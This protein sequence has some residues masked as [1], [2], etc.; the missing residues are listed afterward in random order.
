MALKKSQRMLPFEELLETI[1][2]E[3]LTLKG[4]LVSEDGISSN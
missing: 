1:I 2:R 4:W 3:I